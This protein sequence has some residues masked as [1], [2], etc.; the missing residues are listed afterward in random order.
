M[1]FPTPDEVV[2]QQTEQDRPLHD[3]L[4]VSVKEAI[5]TEFQGGYESF[6]AAIPKGTPARV[7]KRVMV[8][9]HSSGW[10]ATE[11]SDA[12]EGNSWLTITR[13]TSQ[14]YR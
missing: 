5:A 4:C 14:D 13:S 9:L 6:L 3:A 8:E 2:K 7:V 12:R 11:G 10:G 1:G